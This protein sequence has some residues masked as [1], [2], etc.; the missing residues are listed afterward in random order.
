M[1]I[2]HVL[3]LLHLIHATPVT[4]IVYLI[5]CLVIKSNIYFKAIKNVLQKMYFKNVL[6]AGFID[7]HFFHHSLQT[8][9]HTLSHSNALAE[10]ACVTK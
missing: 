9:H 3:M 5:L 4:G 2:N 10:Y 8:T 1:C 6:K 7:P